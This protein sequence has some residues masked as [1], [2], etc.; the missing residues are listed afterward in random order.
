M[1]VSDC[2]SEREHAL[3]LVQRIY[4]RAGLTKENVTRL[5]VM[6]QH[7]AEDTEIIVGKRSSNVVF[8]V[9]L[10]GDGE[11]GLPLESLFHSEVNSM[12]AKGLR[13]AEVSCLA[14]DSEFADERRR[15]E[16][17]VQGISLLLQVARD[18][19]ID[20]LLLAVHPRHAKVY[21]RLLGC[22]RC[23]DVRE[24]A[25][26]RGNPAVLCMHDFAKLDQ[27]RYPFYNRMYTPRYDARQL[28]GTP[29]SE[30]EKQ[31]FEQYLPTDEYAFM[32][33]AG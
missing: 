28:S 18:R 20:R 5:R 30:V 27:V 4:S 1:K 6:R 33:M 23:S 17:F 21:E 32:P 2:R 24:Y 9:S 14:H 7:L 19:K 8:T 22:V 25:A 26:V 11:Y 15:F 29:M 31:Y 13:L 3:Q 16:T 12:R 10:V